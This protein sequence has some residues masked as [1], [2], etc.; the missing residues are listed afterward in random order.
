MPFSLASAGQQTDSA[1]NWLERGNEIHMSIIRKTD[2]E[3]CPSIARVHTSAM[4][5]IP[6]SLYTP[7]L[8]AA[9]SRHLNSSVNAPD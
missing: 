8:N 7:G 6:T 3:D 4:R 5:A 1:E 9:R 2:Q